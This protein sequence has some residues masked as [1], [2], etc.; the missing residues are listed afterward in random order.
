MGT[1]LALIKC[2]MLLKVTSQKVRVKMANGKLIAPELISHCFKSAISFLTAS[3]RQHQVVSNFGMN[4][5]VCLVIKMH[6]I[7]KKTRMTT[8]W[9]KQNLLHRKIR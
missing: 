8:F 9:D 6:A 5:L 7:H 1:S 4:F 2:N 3:G